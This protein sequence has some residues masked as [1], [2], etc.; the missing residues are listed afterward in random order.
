MKTLRQI[1]YIT[2]ASSISSLCSMY[3]E[4]NY[5]KINSSKNLL[6]LSWYHGKTAKLQ[7]EIF[8]YMYLYWGIL[9][10]DRCMYTLETTHHFNIKYIYNICIKFT[11]YCTFYDCNVTKL[12]ILYSV[13]MTMRQNQTLY[14]AETMSGLWAC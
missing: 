11:I 12:D 10:K 1:I 14:R 3:K 9:K 8:L 5:G 2:F 13:H 7:N 6:H 4:W